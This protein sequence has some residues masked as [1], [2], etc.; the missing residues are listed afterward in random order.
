MTFRDSVVNW[1]D[2]AFVR[3]EELAAIIERKT[4][5]AGEELQRRR[6]TGQITGSNYLEVIVPPSYE[7]FV[8]SIVGTEPADAGGGSVPKENFVQYN[9]DLNIPIFN[10]GCQQLPAITAFSYITFGIDLENMREDDG[11]VP[12]SY[13]ITAVL[14]KLWLK[15]NYR[16][17]IQRDGVG[18]APGTI[19]TWRVFY[20]EYKKVN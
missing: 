19:A 8:Y 4:A 5:P 18:G 6:Y 10:I 3:E 2:P 14:P 9:D 13:K 16:I 1:L 7:W 17:Y 12:P 20:L 15:E 11:G